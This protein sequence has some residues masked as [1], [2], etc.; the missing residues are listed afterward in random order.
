M[1]SRGR[2]LLLGAVALALFVAALDAYVVVTLLGRMMADLGLPADRLERATPVI[3]G[4]LLGYIVAMPLLGAVSDRQGRGR[5]LLLS[6]GLFAAGSALTASAGLLG[7]GDPGA[8]LGPIG[9]DGLG[10]P[11]LVAGRVLQGLGG[12]ALVPVALALAADLYPAGGRAPALGAVAAL[13]ETGSVLGPLYGAALAQVAASIGGWRAVFWANLPLVA[14]CAAGWLL[15]GRRAG[16]G[17]PGVAAGGAPLQPAPRVD[18]LGGLLLGLGLGLLVI[19]LYPDDP[20]VRAVGPQ[21]V[22]L[23]IAGAGALLLFARRQATV[24]DPLVGRDLLRSRAFVGAL[25]ANLLVGAGLMVALVDVPILARGVYRLDQLHGALLLARFMFA[26]PIGA[27]A[28][29]WLAQRAGYRAVAVAGLLAAAAAFVLMARWDAGSLA[30]RPLGLPAADLTLGLGGL[31]FGL[32]IAPLAAAILDRARDVEH[33]VASSL[34]VL[35]RTV[36]MLLGLSALTA[37]GL[38]R[39]YQLFNSGPALRLVPGAPDFAAQSAA[40]DARL[41][42]ALL[43]EYHEIFTAAAVLCLAAALLAL[44]TLS[45]GPRVRA[46]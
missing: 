22:P 6:L 46:L 17:G 13:Q 21:F 38:R 23:G 26:I 28:G 25:A 15:A 27:L 29:G 40:F 18:L 34:A 4:F 37:L 44:M 32:V 30:A 31:G 24:A 10:L 43:A 11:W 5:V 19:A 16:P 1:T 45:S 41:T 8:T 3:T 12:G 9:L 14:L 35:A 20:A 2:R 33:G 39:F 7:Q 36:G 42:A